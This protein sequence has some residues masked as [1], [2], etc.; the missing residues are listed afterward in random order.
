MKKEE[1]VKTDTIASVAT[2]AGEGA[3]GIVRL[4]GDESSL[5]L[6]K[7]FRPGKT[8]KRYINHKMYYGTII[9]KTGQPIDQVMIAFMKAP[10]TY[11]GEDMLEVY[12]HGGSGIVNAVLQT[13]IDTGA[14]LAQRGEFT[15]RAFL[16]GKMDLLQSEAVVDLVKADTDAARKQAINQITGKLSQF[17]SSIKGKLVQVK[18]NIEVQIDFPEDDVTPKQLFDL[19]VILQ[20]AYDEVKHV[21]ETYDQAKI[22]RHGISIALVGRPNAGK[23]SLFNIM[24]GENRAIVTSYPG[25]TRDYIEESTSYKGVKLILID[26]AGL[27]NSEEPVEKMGI[28]MTQAQIKRADIIA[29]VIDPTIE[30]SYEEELGI[31]KEYND[32]AILVINKI[33][34]TEAKKVEQVKQIFHY[35]PVY[36]VSAK[37]KE[38]I[39]ALKQGITAPSHAPS[40]ENTPVINRYRHKQVLEH[41]ELVLKAAINLIDEQAFPEI[42]AEEIDSAILALKD[43]TGEVTTED[44]LDRIFSEFCI[45]K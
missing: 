10:G 27:R 26:T 19:K 2:P 12:T 29:V 17:V 43:L 14:R 32:K 13:V 22:I 15:R 28:E 34:I 20:V 30:H 24:L 45:G 37:T 3:I 16:N 40:I 41:T 42:I 1:I 23:S 33:D 11:T 18:E 9:D 44:I 6:K 8:I 39:E 25:T 38:G 21:L 36:A 7:V 4:S 5:I 31:V 35:H